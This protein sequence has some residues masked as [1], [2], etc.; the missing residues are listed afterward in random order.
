MLKIPDNQTMNLHFGCSMIRVL[1]NFFVEMMTFTFYFLTFYFYNLHFLSI[2]LNIYNLRN[3]C[4][5]QY[6]VNK[7]ND[8]IR[9]LN[10]YKF[11]NLQIY[12]KESAKALIFF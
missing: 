12:A 6:M 4:V 10:I 11:L 5:N 1:I 2:T 3:L 7:Y 9:L 8:V